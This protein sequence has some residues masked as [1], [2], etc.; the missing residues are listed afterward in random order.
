MSNTSTP[1][2]SIRRSA[3]PCLQAFQDAANDS[4][5]S[6]NSERLQKIVG[7][8]S[9][10]GRHSQ[11]GLFPFTIRGN[12]LQ[13]K[14][15]M[16]GEH[17]TSRIMDAAKNDEEKDA[18]VGY[19]TGATCWPA[20][21]VLCKYLERSDI[22]NAIGS[23]RTVIELGGGTGMVSLAAALLGAETVVCTDGSE[24]VVRL[25]EYN[26]A[27]HMHLIVE[28]NANSD[29]STCC[30][31]WG[32]SVVLPSA[33]LILVSDCV[34]PKIFPVA[35]LVD[36]L[37]DLMGAKTL[38]IVSYEHRHFEEYHP[39]DKFIELAES[40]GLSVYVVPMV[41]HDHLYSVEDIEIWQVKRKAN[42]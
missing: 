10:R 38:C 18:L 23:K 16:G 12:E 4:A 11:A 36:A 14:Q 26:I 24:D 7:S 25:A 9:W 37:D 40:K 19:G 29:I 33:D 34:L 22:I 39:R 15:I 5:N 13:I 32:E 28:G 17:E 21:L 20:S 30:Y 35:P 2:A 31:R 1:A 6:S 3:H 42:S 27:Q 8:L 41:D